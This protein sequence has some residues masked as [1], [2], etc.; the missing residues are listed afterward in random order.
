MATSWS[1]LLHPRPRSQFLRFCSWVRA[2]R[3]LRNFRDAAPRG[4][5]LARHY[6]IA[7]IADLAAL[8]ADSTVWVK[9]ASP[10]NSAV[11]CRIKL[12]GLMLARSV[13]FNICMAM[14]FTFG[15]CCG[16]PRPSSAGRGRFSVLTC[17]QF[18]VHVSNFRAATRGL[19]Y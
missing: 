8:L 18:R 1:A 16:V 2:L 9:R 10:E 11:S 4:R 12:V 3:H 17:R 14:A 15:R 5:C 6:P 13:P 7:E 19:A